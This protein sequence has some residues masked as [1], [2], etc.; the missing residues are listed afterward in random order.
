MLQPPSVNGM[1]S[2]MDR[3]RVVF[4]RARELPSFV[5]VRC[6]RTL[7]TLDHSLVDVELERKTAPTTRV[8]L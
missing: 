8:I 6:V 3:I 2:G 1:E 4:R 5:W 7:N